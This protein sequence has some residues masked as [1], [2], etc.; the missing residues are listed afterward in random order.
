MTT[1][2]FSSGVNT[3]FSS[4]LNTN[5]QEVTKVL[6]TRLSTTSTTSTSAVTVDTINLT[7]HTATTAYRLC[8]DVSMSGPVVGNAYITLRF[9]DGANNTDIEYEVDNSFDAS[10]TFSVF[11]I[12]PASSTV[13]VTTGY[14]IIDGQATANTSWHGTRTTLSSAGTW[15]NQDTFSVRMRVGT[16]GTLTMNSYSFQRIGV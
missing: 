7:N 2:T 14:T 10:T 4:Q 15:A 8:V 9:T 3:S 5:F 13:V 1:N 11:E 6:A 16:S 12:Y